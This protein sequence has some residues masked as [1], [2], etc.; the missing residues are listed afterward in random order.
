MVYR[1]AMEANTPLRFRPAGL[2]A[3]LWLGLLAPAW[4]QPVDPA[5]HWP[6]PPAELTRPSTSMNPHRDVP[7]AERGD[8]RIGNAEE[9]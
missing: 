5:V 3:L 6:L 2:A 1:L 9:L 7:R 4:G 8:P